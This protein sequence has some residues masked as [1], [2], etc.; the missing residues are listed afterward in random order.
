MDEDGP[1]LSYLDSLNPAQLTGTVVF[2]DDINNKPLIL[3]ISSLSGLAPL[4]NSCNI[5]ERQSSTN[6]GRSGIGENESS[7]C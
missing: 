4:L 7:Y 1:D 2:P 5:P 3:S 6:S